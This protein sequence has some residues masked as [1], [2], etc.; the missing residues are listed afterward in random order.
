M[1]TTNEHTERAELI[2]GLRDLAEIDFDNLFMRAAAMLEASTQREQPAATASVCK[3]IHFKNHDC[4]VEHCKETCFR[5]M[6]DTISLP[7]ASK[8]KPQAEVRVPDGY[9]LVPESALRWLFG[10]EDAFECPP[11]KYFRGKPPAYLWRSMFL[12]MLAAAPKPQEDLPAILK[13]QAS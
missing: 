3:S 12:D 5:E 7:A 2:K 8:P 1:T 10:E 13:K 6:N 4:V 11:E 9:V